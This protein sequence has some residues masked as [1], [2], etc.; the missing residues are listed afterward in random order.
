MTSWAT[1]D[2]YLGKCGRRSCTEDGGL[3]ARRRRRVAQLRTAFVHGGRWSSCTE[4]APSCPTADG[5]RARRRRRVGQV[6]MAFVHGGWWS[7]C[8]EAATSWATA[9]GV[10]ARREVVFVHGGGDELPNCGRRSCTEGGGLRARSRRRVGQVRTLSWANQDAELGKSGRRLGQVRTPTW[11]SQ[12]AEL[13]KSGRRVGQV[14]TPSWASQDAE[15]GKS[16]RRVGQVRTLSW[17]NQDAELGNCG[18]RSCTEDDGLR[19]FS[20]SS[21]CF[22]AVVFVLSRCRLRARRRLSSAA[23]AI[24]FCR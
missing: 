12:D 21:S 14:R 9:D 22:L 4:A 5:V 3:R 8:T 1:A 19:A 17:A 20:P 10:R 11:A 6:R 13:G 2:D 15:L 16:G 18:R 7:S 23:E 24:V